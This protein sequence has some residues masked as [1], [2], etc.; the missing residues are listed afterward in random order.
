MTQLLLKLIIKSLGSSCRS[1]CSQMFVD[2]LLLV[3]QVGR[4]HH[5]VHQLV[6][7]TAP[8]VQ[9]FQWILNKRK[10]SKQIQ[11]KKTDRF[12]VLAINFVR[13][14]NDLIMV[15]NSFMMLEHCL[16]KTLQ[17]TSLKVFQSLSDQQIM[18]GWPYDGVRSIKTLHFSR[19][20]QDFNPDKI[21]LSNITKCNTVLG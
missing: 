15:Q 13:L 18:L 10:T 3:D 11:Q 17:K 14:L 5:Q 2:H 8:G 19:N 9:G 16:L 20:H 1:R 4:L 7:V 21:M 12:S 6:G